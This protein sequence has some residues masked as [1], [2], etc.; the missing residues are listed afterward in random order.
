MATD[1]DYCY[2][3]SIVTAFMSYHDLTFAERCLCNM[4]DNEGNHRHGPQYLYDLRRNRIKPVISKI[5]ESV[6]LDIANAGFEL[7]EMQAELR[8]VC[9]HVLDIDASSA[10]IMTIQGLRGNAW[11]FTDVF[12][13]DL[14]LWILTHYAGNLEVSVGGKIVYSKCL[15][16]S[17]T[18]LTVAVRKICDPTQLE[19]GYGKDASI[20][21][22]VGEGSLSKTVFAVDSTGDD[23]RG[24]FMPTLRRGLYDLTHIG[25]PFSDGE[26]G[27][28]ILG[29]GELKDIGAASQAIVR[30]LLKVPL[31]AA[32]WSMDPG[33]VHLQWKGFVIPAAPKKAGSLYNLGQI[34]SRLPSILHQNYGVITAELVT[35]QEPELDERLAEINENIVMSLSATDFD[36]IERT[37]ECFPQASTA[38]VRIRERCHRSGCQDCG[39]TCSL[40]LCRPGCLGE[41]ALTALLTTL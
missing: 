23:V 19:H 2:V 1:D 40:G 39:G 22:S 7:Q 15:G 21:I 41:A 35:F 3:V 5:V 10:A 33:K 37:I 29:K 4:A 30:W 14:S 25:R 26:F 17:S 32:A 13:V 36:L 34:F 6:A 11:V 31:V 24:Q 18:R 8:G 20:K 16:S 28:A 12:Y 27:Q 9:G 38:I